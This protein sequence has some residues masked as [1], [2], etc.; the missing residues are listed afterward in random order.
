MNLLKY[1]FL[2]LVLILVSCSSH[3]EH[4]A[5]DKKIYTPSVSKGF[6][7]DGYENSDNTVISVFNPWQ[8]AQGVESTLMIVRNDKE[9]EGYFGKLLKGDARRII[10][11]SSTHIAMLD[12]LDATDRIVAVSGKEYVSNPK[13]RERFDSLTDIGYEG[14]FDYESIL[15]LKPDLVLLFSVNGE[16][17]LQR[18]L[19]EFGIPY[20]YIGDFVEEDPLG[21]AEW[22]VPLAEIVGKREKGIGKFNEISAKYESLKNKVKEANLPSPTVMLNTPFAD[23]WFMPSSESYVA[24]M[25]KDAGADYI[26]KKNTGSASMP[27]DMEEAFRLVSEADFWLNTGA[28][29]SLEELKVN[30]P[31]LAETKCVEE[32]RVYNNNFRRTPE[33]GNDCY[34]SGVVNPD[35]ILRDL[36]KIFHPQLVEEDFVYYHQLK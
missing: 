33:G 28:L 2:V 20:I 7:I 21:K 10:C 11:L 29:T 18:R 9:P 35:L 16:S 14:N 27:I 8:N 5:P 25:M 34:E 36:I 30:L 6:S 12:A 15:A 4:K 1:K 22:I 24:G 19:D 13:L 3:Q 26:Y 17:G 31:K 23:S 32:G